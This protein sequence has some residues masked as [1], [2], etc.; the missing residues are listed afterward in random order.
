MR[1]T[2]LY[3]L[4]TYATAYSVSPIESQSSTTLSRRSFGA[5][6]ASA[7]GSSSALSRS[8]AAVAKSDQEEIDKQNILKGYSRLTYLLDNWVDETTICGANDNPYTGTKG[9]ERNPMKVMD[10]MGFK[11]IKDPLFKADKTMRRLER[12]VPAS[13][14]SDYIEAI[15]KFS[16]AAEE[17]SNMAYVSS[18]GEANPGGGKDRVELFIERAKKNVIDARDSLSTV[19]EICEL[20]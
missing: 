10:Y 13:R 20:K 12:L 5:T 15:E 19:I 8:Q 2:L 14:E 7:L 18:W 6:V 11:S 4:V 3:L 17:A 16:E 1:A 9:C